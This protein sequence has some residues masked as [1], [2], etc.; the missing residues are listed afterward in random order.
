[1]SV[2][3]EGIVGEDAAGLKCRKTSYEK[4]VED[5][6]KAVLLGVERR[7]RGLQKAIS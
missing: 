5:E 3:M 1:M 6:R 2:R 7:R 4:T